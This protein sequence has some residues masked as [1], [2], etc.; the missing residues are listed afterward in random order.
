[1]DKTRMRDIPPLAVRM[2]PEVRARVIE[3]ANENRRSVSG[4]ILFRIE[5]S[6]S[7]EPKTKKPAAEA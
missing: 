1:M 7:D 4:E 6:L 3:L 5:Q 2:P